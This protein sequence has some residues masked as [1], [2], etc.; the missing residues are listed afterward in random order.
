MSG[1]GINKEICCDVNRIV[2]LVKFERV[3]IWIPLVLLDFSIIEFFT[4]IELQYCSRSSQWICGVETGYLGALGLCCIGTFIG[5]CFNSRCSR[6]T[7]W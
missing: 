5:I 7:A 1:G 6:S 3:V 2:T 4:S